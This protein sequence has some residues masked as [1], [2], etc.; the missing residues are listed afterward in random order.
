MPDYRRIAASIDWTRVPD[1]YDFGDGVRE[2]YQ[3]KRSALQ[4][5]SRGAKLKQIHAAFNVSRQVLYYLLERWFQLDIDGQAIE[6]RALLPY[7]QRKRT[8]TSS[9]LGG[10]CRPGQLQL[11]FRNQPKVHKALVDLVLHGKLEGSKV[12]LDSQAIKPKT[13]RSVLHDTAAACDIKAPDFPFVGKD[14]GLRA[15]DEWAKKTRS[16]HLAQQ[17]LSELRQQQSNPWREQ[18]QGGYPES[19]KVVQCDGHSAKVDLSV[20][21]H[22]TRDGHTWIDV[23]VSRIWVIPMYECRSGAILGYSH[24]FGKNYSASDVARA[25][26]HAQVPWR[27]RALSDPSLS[28]APGDGLPSGIDPDLEFLCWDVLALDG[29]AA[30]TADLLLCTL[31]R[32]VNCVIDIGPVAAPNVRSQ[33]EGFFSAFQEALAEIIA[34]KGRIIRLEL[35]L[36]LLDLYVARYNNSICPGTSMTHMEVLRN[37]VKSDPTIVRRVPEGLRSE[38]LKYDVFARAY[39][40][41][42]K[43]KRVLNWENAKYEGAGLAQPYVSVGDEIAFATNSRDVRSL[44]ARLSKDGRDLGV[45]EVEA[46]FRSTAHS[47]VT[48]RQAK[49]TQGVQAEDLVLAVARLAQANS[50]MSQSAAAVAAR[51]AEEMHFASST[52]LLPG[53][54]PDASNVFNLPAKTNAE[55]PRPL[56]VD[57][58]ARIKNLGSTY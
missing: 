31:E 14:R 43:G 17:Q 10:T 15:I 46:R 44:Q 8:Y 25:A 55:P 39:V 38:C 50:S 47:T 11:L 6:H 48:R 58:I 1:G 41:L 7:T 40:T 24:A 18:D 36:D 33:V 30:H 19:L 54:T 13:L 9:K 4:Q 35:F 49:A 27:P 22:A 42:H 52:P 32:T 28:Y 12:R 26:N 37:E 29:A 56:D 57:R 23:P 20:R 5:Y 34:K 2:G 45:L 16:R 53:P 21:M 51:T 3:S